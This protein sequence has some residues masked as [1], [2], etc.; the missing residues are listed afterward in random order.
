MSTKRTTRIS[1][2]LEDYLEAILNQEER[3]GAARVRDIAASVSVHKSTVTAALHT[4]AEKRLVNYVPY[5]PITLTE[6]GRRIAERV[7]HDHDVIRA[8]LR[9]ILLVDDE[10]AEENACRMEHVIDRTVLDRL[11]VFAKYMRDRQAAGD[12]CW[13]EYAERL[14]K[15]VG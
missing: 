10:V 6:S 11:V 14:T 7:K 3:E 13:G 9:D 12:A 15:E 5:G 2:T 8:F 1:A 4:L